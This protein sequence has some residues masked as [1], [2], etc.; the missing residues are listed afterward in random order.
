M[1]LLVFIC[2]ED[3]LLDLLLAGLH[4][5]LQLVNQG[6]HAFMILLVFICSEDQLLDAAF[7]FPQ[8]LANISIAP[9]LC[10]KVGFQ[11]TDASLH[12]DHGLPAS[13]QSIDF[14]LISPGSSV[15]ALGL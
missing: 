15:L 1:I 8:V 9:A 6:L 2:S 3:Q 5:A 11:L 10:I 13:L 4:L 14:S 12:L 7:R